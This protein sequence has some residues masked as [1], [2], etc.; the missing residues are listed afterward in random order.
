MRKVQFVL[1]AVILS[2]GVI[3][4]SAI[5]SNTIESL[6]KKDDIV[7][8]K[9]V[10]EKKVKSDQGMLMITVKANDKDINT[11]L[12]NLKQQ[13]SELVSTLKANDFSD[14][15]IKLENIISE[16]VYFYNENGNPTTRVLSYNVNQIVNITTGKVDK[17]SPLALK[18][19][20]NLNLSVS[21]AQYL[22]T[23]VEKLKIDL[24]GEATKNA[25]LRATELV[26]YNNRSIGGLKSVNQGVFQITGDNN[27]ETSDAGYYD[28]YS[29]EKTVRAVISIEYRVE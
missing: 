14:S 29:I 3:I 24:L 22:V 16:P 7:S 9:G 28:T 5:V 13:T 8:V 1:V 2:L 12:E 27:S 19:S 26:K 11:A 10:A 15:E 6:K 4:S 21:D 25:K 20:E 18:L 17:L 23:N